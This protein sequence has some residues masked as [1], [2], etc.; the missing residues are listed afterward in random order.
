MDADEIIIHYKTIK[1]TIPKPATET[2]EK[3]R[4]FYNQDTTSQQLPYNNLTQK[5]KDSSGVY[6]R[7]PV[8]VMEITLKKAFE[9]FCL[10]YPDVKIGQRSFE[11]LRPRNICLRQYTQRLHCCCTY[12]INMDFIWNACKKLFMVNGKDCPFPNSD[13][14]VSAAL[15]QPNSLKCILPVC[16]QC[17]I[18]YKIS[19]L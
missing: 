19:N 2:I 11:H 3:V 12:H 7:V 8:R 13:A 17:K 9:L 16:S 10:Q 4:D 6:H 14:L 1:L 5:I 15:C 18:F